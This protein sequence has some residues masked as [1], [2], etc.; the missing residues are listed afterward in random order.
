MLNMARG[1]RGQTPAGT[2]EVALYFLAAVAGTAALLA[3]SAARIRA[4]TIAFADR[5]AGSERRRRGRGR[6]GSEPDLDLRPALWLEWARQHDN[7]AGR[8][9]GWWLGSGGIV[10]AAAIA[11][12][13][14]SS[15]FRPLVPAVFLLALLVAASHL[16]T[17]VEIAGHVAEDRENR[18]FEMLATTTLESADILEDRSARARLLLRRSCVVLFA[19]VVVLGA[20]RVGMGIH[21]ALTGS[22]GSDDPGAFFI[23]QALLAAGMAAAAGYGF[24]RLTASIG[25]WT[26]LRFRSPFRAMAAGIGVLIALNVGM[27]LAALGTMSRPPGVSGL[28]LLASPWA[29]F[30]CC[31]AV[32]IDPNFPRQEMGWLATA[33]HL[34]LALLLIVVARML[35]RRSARRLEIL[36]RD[37]PRKS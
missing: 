16:L 19:F 23:F 18:H 13:G 12:G 1:V 37:V 11:F 24:A 33:A 4:T 17:F 10:V 28:L 26:G 25:V 30:V 2:R 35:D 3:W 9:N 29:N 21:H 36:L 15:G 22:G 32:A 5:P 14:L 20:S 6:R 27:F 7:L 34:P 31:G 8:L